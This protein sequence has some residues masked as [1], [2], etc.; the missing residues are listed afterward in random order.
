[1]KMS[2]SYFFKV[3]LL[4]TAVAVCQAGIVSANSLGKVETKAACP[5]FLQGNTAVPCWTLNGKCY[6]FSKTKRVNWLDADKFC[7]V[8]GM[9]LLSLESK[10]EDQMIN[11]HIKSTSELSDDYYWISGKF[12]NNR[13]EWANNEP[14][15]YT[16]WYTGEPS[17][18]QA[19]I[20]F[21]YINYLFPNGIWFDEFGSAY[22]LFICES[23]DDET[24][25]VD[26]HTTE[27][28]VPTDSTTE[29]DV[30]TNPTTEKDVPTEPTTEKDV[31]TNPTTEKE[32]PTNPTTEKDVPTEPTTEAV[33]LTTTKAT[34][35]EPVSTTTE[36]SLEA[37]ARP[38]E[39]TT[40]SSE[41]TTTAGE[42]TPTPFFCPKYLQG[43]ISMPCWTLSDK[44]Y[45]F[46][47]FVRNW[48][49]ADTYCKQAGMTLLKIETKEENNLIVYHH[50]HT[51]GMTKD[52]Y[53]TSGR[54]SQEGNKRWEWATTQP[55]QQLSYTN[56]N[57]TKPVQP[58]FNMPGYCIDI[59]FFQ[60]GHWFD[61][62]CSS[63][64]KFI[65]ESK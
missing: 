31:P 42:T 13:W 40:E 3:F 57:P 60:T 36:E 10:E 33:E 34:T 61:G 8:G 32:V 5:G 43:N 15:T 2:S 47:K 49:R 56:W 20:S 4:A 64:M 44:C 52:I 25:T 19:G 27:K 28:D 30:P 55:Y 26:T 37:T 39:I 21:V 17:Y 35:I 6:C 11:N 29:K 41:T 7:R 12:S 63:N 46:S 50:T 1:M 53:W 18:N 59:S 65:C 51:P 54:Y 45:C 9:T 23:I 62:L 48:T 38:E 14:L 16:H 58:D 24:T 22:I